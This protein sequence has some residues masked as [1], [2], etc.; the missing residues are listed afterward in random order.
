MINQTRRKSIVIFLLMVLISGS[1]IPL[2]SADP[3]ERNETMVLIE[4]TDFDTISINALLAEFIATPITING[5]E[6]AHLMLKDEGFSYTFGQAKLP[7]IRRMVEIPQGA[8]IN[9][10]INDEIWQHTTLADL[11]MPEKI[12]P[13]QP[14]E[15]DPDNDDSIFIDDD[16]YSTDHYFPEN[17]ISISEINQIRGRRFVL[18]ELSPIQY[19]PYTGDLRFMVSFDATM[20]LNNSSIQN[21]IQKITKFSTESYESV[22]KE[23]FSNYGYYE[24]F[25][26]SDKDTEGYLIIVYD[27]FEDE[28]DPLASWK[29]QIGFETTVTA[30][31]EIPGGV[32]TDNIKSYIQDAYE[33]WATPPAYVLLVGDTSQIPAFTGISGGETD[34]YYVTMDADVFADIHIG[35]FPA[36]NENHVIAMVEKT[37][38]YEEGVFPS[39]DWI[40]K[41]AFIASSDYGQLAEETHNYV[42]DTHLEPNGYT[43]DKIYEASGGNTQ[44]IYDALNDGRSLCIYS[45]HGSSNGWGCVPFYKSDVYALENEGMYPFVCSHAC[46]TGTFENSECFGESWVRAENKGALAFWGSSIN[47]EWNPDDIIERRVFDAWWNDGLDRI[48]QM[49]D[50][51]MYDSYQQYGSYMER[52]ILSY[53]ILGDPSV[54]LWSEESNEYDINQNT[55]N[56]GFPIRQTA[57]GDWGAAQSFM[58]TADVFTEAFVYIR[59]FGT[60]EFDLTVELRIDNPE[61]VIID[62]II[63][64]VEDVQSSWNWINLD[65][66]NITVT[67][68]TEYFIVIPY[69]PSGVTTSFGYEW[70]YAFGNQYDDGSF[71]FTRD[72]GDLWRDLPSR[73]DF[74]F[75]TLGYSS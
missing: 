47:T 24:S 1:F 5:Q 63:Y 27:D 10:V 64:N 67:P 61:G 39:Y 21:T 7:M 8:E 70:G 42:I 14:T 31:S 11:N 36:A 9:I 50:K 49:T 54:K 45:G 35:R 17:I 52:F 56:R 15:K 34:T 20:H 18:L 30:T 3:E 75:R 66:I 51:G 2:L 37:I 32:S 46:V 72:G 22:F 57:D 69:P 62:T 25:V 59:K 23:T 40:Q 58:P 41:A 19:N 71:W 28:I 13:V 29:T 44:D 60:P 73:Y 33:N 12:V 53:N 48:G 6:F 65:F 74:T 55:F 4:N 43:C 38:Y 68:G 16:Y 26:P